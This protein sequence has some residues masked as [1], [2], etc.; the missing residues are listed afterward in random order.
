MGKRRHNYEYS[1]DLL[2]DSAPGAV[3][4]MVRDRSKVLE[5]GA[6]PGSITRYLVSQKQCQLVAL[7]VDPAALDKLREVCT[8]VYQLDLNVLGWSK[9]LKDNHGSFDFVIAAD[10]LE[11]TY[12]PVA[13]LLEMKGLLND[14]GSVILSLPHAGHAAVLSC[15]VDEDF[16]Y[17]N[18]GLLDRTH[19]RFFGIKNIDALHRSAGLAVEQSK[20]IV[21]SPEMTEFSARWKKLPD[22]VKTALRLNR[23]SDVYQVVARAVPEE[24]ANKSISLIHETVPAVGKSVGRY[25]R[26]SMAMLPIDL[27]RDRRSTIA[28]WN[29]KVSSAPPRFRG[30]RR[31]VTKLLLRVGL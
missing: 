13:I 29:P 3:V 18:W 21:R 15:L 26:S 23:Y 11:H 28:G 27:S 8:D 9:E 16:E 22:D 30:I 14:T 4:S 31:L 24:R 6:G 19:V 25:W 1:I 12:D 20:F 17:R 7:E 2:T 10:V 5:I